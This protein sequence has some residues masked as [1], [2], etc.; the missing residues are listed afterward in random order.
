VFA[1][2]G[3]DHRGDAFFALSLGIGELAEVDFELGNWV[4]VCRVCDGDDRHADSLI[5][6]TAQFKM[7]LAERQIAGWQPAFALGLRA[8]VGDRSVTIEGAEVEVEAARLYVV[9]AKTVGPV[10]FHAGADAWDARDG[11]VLLR[12][13]PIAARVRPFVGLEWVPGIYPRTTLLADFGFA[14]VI[15][16]AKVELRWL[17]GWGVRYQAL[18]WGSIELAMRHREGDSL[19]DSTVMV[20]LNAAVGY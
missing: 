11:D 20:R 7:G 6:S 3:V 18:S 16:P 14:P 2:T 1:S 15:E 4:G 17:G 9:L 19:G 10:V 5:L 12:T 13:R 8:P